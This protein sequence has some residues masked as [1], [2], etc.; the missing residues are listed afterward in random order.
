[1]EHQVVIVGAGVAG[2]A[3]AQALLAAGR[4]PLVLEAR[5][6]VGGRVLTDRALAPVEL[7]AEFI[8][9]ERATTWRV[10]R[11]A[12]LRTMPWQGPRRFSVG[13]ALLPEGHPLAARVF[14]RYEALDGYA[15]PAVSVSEALA[16]LGPADEAAALAGRWVANIEGADLAR[17]DARRLRWEHEHTSSG[18]Q[19]FHLPDGYDAV[20]AHL[21]RGVAVRLGAAV[22]RVAWDAGGAALYLAGGEELRARRVVVTAPLPLL[23]A[24]A[25]RFDPPLPEAKRRALGA[26][27]MGQVTKLVLRFREA[28]WPALRAVSTDGA[29]ATWWPVGDAGRPALMGYTG[30]PDALA[31]AARGEEAAV[32]QGLDEAAALFGPRL[33][34]CFVGGRMADWSRDPWSRGAYTY[35]PLGMG[36]ARA[37]LAAPV[38]GTL[39]FAGEASVTSGHVGTVHG[40]IETG[41]RAAEEILADGILAAQDHIF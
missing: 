23:A 32:A 16:A 7:G 38:A 22:E 10:V 27:A 25:P 21:A 8:H 37:E 24:D 15:G 4:S 2:L 30:G 33:R 40:A 28:C 39:F 34:E 1:M 11:E 31:L 35:S 20:P 19:N 17:L 36:D 12:G 5:G 29:V 14:A 6:R 9:G 13:G 18:P 3:A 26:I 41:W